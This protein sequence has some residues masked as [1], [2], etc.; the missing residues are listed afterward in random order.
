M[1]TP[2]F[3]ASAMEARIAAVQA[4]YEVREQARAECAAARE[5]LDAAEVAFN[6]AKSSAI[7]EIA[8]QAGIGSFQL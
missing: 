2:M 7:G 4:A 3:D 5:C 6:A 1:T 8:S